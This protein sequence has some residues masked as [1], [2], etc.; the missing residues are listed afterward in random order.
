MMKLAAA[1]VILILANAC[2]PRTVDGQ[3]RNQQWDDSA[4]Y[5][6]HGANSSSNIRSGDATVVIIAAVAGG[7][8]GVIFAHAMASLGETGASTKEVVVSGLIGATI[9]AFIGLFAVSSSSP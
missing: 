8:V 6:M 3:R 2:L 4:Y 9:G 5:G 1:M 7:G